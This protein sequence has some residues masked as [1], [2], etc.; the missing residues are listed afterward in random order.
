MTDTGIVIAREHPTSLDAPAASPFVLRQGIASRDE[1]VLDRLFTL[2]LG[3][4]GNDIADLIHASRRR[5]GQSPPLVVVAHQP[6][7][8][9]ATNIA[10]TL[11][12]AAVIAEAVDGTPVFVAIDYDEAGDQRFRSPHLPPASDGGEEAFL[13]G[14]VPKR[15]RRVPAFALPPPAPD[16]RNMWRDR[17]GQAVLHWRRRLGMPGRFRP[18]D[19]CFD[20]EAPSLTAWGSEQL[21]RHLAGDFGISLE[22]NSALAGLRATAPERTDLLQLIMAK[23]PDL[24]AE[25]LWRMCSQCRGRMPV[26]LLSTDHAE[27]ACG[28]CGTC[29]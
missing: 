8:C 19:D 16:V 1:E 27:W 26:R 2:G 12:C 7:M 4:R 14:A 20:F 10:S 17:H 11:V 22:A 29:Q 18:L 6:N 28:P 21:V 9:A 15:S 23:R 3:V 24:S 13:A 25:L 5:P